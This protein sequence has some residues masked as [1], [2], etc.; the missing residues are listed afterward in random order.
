[1]TPGSSFL[2][3]Y[4]AVR[5]STGKKAP[6]VVFPLLKAF[7]LI[8]YCVLLLPVVLI[9]MILRAR[10]GPPQPTPPPTTASGY[11]RRF[12]DHIDQLQEDM[13]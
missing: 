13:K 7:A 5:F 11:P 6:G 8:C 10:P 3:T 4:A 12:Q 2:S 9:Q 1:M